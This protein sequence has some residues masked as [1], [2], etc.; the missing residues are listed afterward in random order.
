MSRVVA[1]VPLKEHSQ[2][3][4]GKN[5]AILG[6]KPLYESILE[7]LNRVHEIDQIYIYSSSSLFKV[8]F[9]QKSSKIVFKSRSKEL[10]GDDVSINQVLRAF[11]EDI[12]ADTIIL[13]HATSP[14][15]SP[16]TIS[17]CVKKV[18]EGEHDSALAAIKLNKFAVY[19][20]SSL[21]FDRN[22]DLPPLQKIEPVVI[23]QGG[24]YVFKKSD[25]LTKNRR[26]GNHP[27][28]QYVNPKESIDIDTAEDFELA[29]AVLLTQDLNP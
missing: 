6:K 28:F 24:L 15:I 3:F 25:F 11:L 9:Q 2:R 4:P 10:D 7:S 21:N 14:F 16:E 22:E 13:A 8:P 17:I 18:T 26:V 20:G 23:E 19:C 5:L 29:K 27:H 1:V 12:Q